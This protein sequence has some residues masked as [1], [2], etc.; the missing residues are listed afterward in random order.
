MSKD[1]IGLSI[2]SKN[3]VIG[4]YINGSFQVV[5]TETSSRS[6]PTVVSYNNRERNFGEIASNKNRA[7]YKTTVIYPNRWL[8]IQKNYSFYHEEEK[9]A[10]I[11]PKNNN[12]NLLSFNINYKGQKDFYTPECLMALFFNK[13]KNIWIK[14]NIN[15]NH[16]VLSI[17]DY[18]TVQERKAM[19]ESVTISGLNCSSLLNESSAIALAYGFRKL[20]EFQDDK[21]RLVCFIDL[22]HSQ[23]TIFYA[24]FTK[25]L[26]EVISV[27]SERFCGARD[28]DY[29]IAEKISYDFQKRYGN[30][31][32]DS[33]KSK[34][35]LMN[36]INKARKTLTVNKEVNIN[37]DSL[38]D[39][40]DI[41]Y[42]LTRQNFEEIISPVLAKFENLCKISLQ[43]IMQLGFNLKQLYGVEMVG[44]TLR[45]PI[46]NEIIKKV[47]N[48]ELSKSLL[49]DEC[50]ARGC[51]L[52]AMMNSPYYAIKNFAFKHYNPYLI[53]LEIPTINQYGQ[54]IL[55]YFNIFVEGENFPSNKTITLHR[56]QLPFRNQ[57]QVKL[58]YSPNEPNL[59]FLPNKL[60]N[61]YDIYLPLEKQTEWILNITF[62]LDINCLPSLASV[63]IKEVIKGSVPVVKNNNPVQNNI[64]NANNI[65]YNNINPNMNNQQFQEEIKEIETPIK[66]DLTITTFGTPYNVLNDYIIREKK[67]NDEDLLVNETIN[68]KNHLEQYIYDTRSK[69]D[70]NGQLSGYYVNEEK[71]ELFKKMDD[72]MNWLYSEDE[73]LYNKEKLEEKSKDMRDIGDQIY[74]RFNEWN[75]LDKQYAKIESLINDTIMYCSNVE[76]QI[77]NGKKTDLSLEDI[78]EI[79]NLI[80]DTLRKVAEKKNLSDKRILTS[81]PPVLTDEIEM[82]I[83]N[84][85]YTLEDIRENAKKRKEE[86]EKKKKEL[87]KENEEK[88]K[89]EE[90]KEKS[91]DNNKKQDKKK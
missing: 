20:K 11:P 30:D 74:K 21:P 13:I 47:F 42:N 73:D 22:G 15:T 34:I 23:T 86:E 17:P 27:T 77:K 29:L 52:F 62:N 31:P 54:E 89:N 24:R 33:P 28:F 60:I 61:V 83:N 49:P 7:N 26:I 71:N 37:I 67:Q 32:L 35:S 16:I 64:N 80:N 10:N 46:I 58:L 44:D 85:N 36:A 82:I 53:L 19:L 9:Y 91:K 63:T 65:N 66:A 12:N 51:A 3:T 50:I 8:G 5:L 43:K 1:I 78:G 48:C 18:S 79:R 14:H 70:V 45:T 2:G 41:S 87:E 55:T 76:T 90:K 88:R 72:L 59:S 69:M 4:T 6:T 38:L 68:Y 39:G 25:S 84:F 57:I 40:H 75:K 81:L 56:Y